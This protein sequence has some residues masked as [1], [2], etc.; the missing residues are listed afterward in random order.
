QP[1]R[2]RSLAVRRDRRCQGAAGHP[3]LSGRS[4][5]ER[6]RRWSGHRPRRCGVLRDGGRARDR[7]G[8]PRCSYKAL[9]RPARAAA[10]APYGAAAGPA[11]HRVHRP[12][13][14]AGCGRGPADLREAKTRSATRGRR[15]RREISGPR[16]AAAAL[17]LHLLAIHHPQRASLALAQGWADRG[18]RALDRYRARAPGGLRDLRERPRS[19]SALDSGTTRRAGREPDP[20][21]SRR[22]RAHLQPE[23]ARARLGPRVI[24]VPRRPG[25]GRRA[26][27][28]DRDRRSGMS[29]LRTVARNVA[30]L[31]ASRIATWLAA[32]AFTIAQA[33][34]LG[35]GHFGE[36]SVALT[37]AALLAI[38]MDFGLG[39][40]LSRMVAQR[41]PGHEQALVATIAIRGGLW[42]VAAPALLLVCVALGYGPELRL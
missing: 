40:Q 32:F 23:H 8:G 26:S 1:G 6:L 31:T 5:L 21:L 29:V 18:V 42:L 16:A 38:V 13:G 9:L 10:G 17:R 20:L 39:T 12:R 24:D 2:R 37:Y 14:R 36:L 15:R 34:Y 3:Q 28:C 4:G 41:S 22:P 11:A 30:M 33:R 27:S 25:D 19:P 7:H 35:P